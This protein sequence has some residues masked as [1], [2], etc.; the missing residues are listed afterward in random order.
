MFIDHI[1]TV[2]LHKLNTYIQAKNVLGISKAE[3]R[4]NACLKLINDAGKLS[5]ETLPEW[6][7]DAGI[8]A[9]KFLKEP[10]TAFSSHECPDLL[11][12]LISYIKIKERETPNDP[13]CIRFKLARQN[14]I[15]KLIATSGLETEDRAKKLAYLDDYG[16]DSKTPLPPQDIKKYFPASEPVPYTGGAMN[17][18]YYTYLDDKELVKDPYRD[19]NNKIPL[20][21][22]PLWLLFHNKEK[23]NKPG[24]I[25]RFF[26]I[27]SGVDI[28]QDTLKSLQN[29]QAI[30]FSQQTTASSSPKDQK[31][32]TE[33]QPLLKYEM[34][35]KAQ[36]ESFAKQIE[37]LR[38]SYDERVRNLESKIETDVAKVKISLSGQSLI[39]KHAEEISKLKAEH[40]VQIEAL[41]A[42]HDKAI[43]QLQE[44][45]KKEIENEV[46][47]KVD[48][49]LK[50]IQNDHKTALDEKDKKMTE[51]EELKQKLISEHKSAL[52]AK[53][54]AL[55]D[56][57]ARL[58]E[59]EK[60]KDNTDTKTSSHSNAA[61]MGK[62]GTLASPATAKPD[63]ANSTSSS[64]KTKKLAN[65]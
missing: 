18:F 13:E 43:R 34:D 1:R 30:I 28:I 64:T 15:Q 31:S 14:L 12:E 3:E 57:I 62:M 27:T 61:T 60:E 44:T 52:D 53:E 38:K 17:Y 5:P 48:A 54:A 41:K 2:V 8:Y 19:M 55:T 21:L 29:A 51:L 45:H 56:A 65:A 25:A 22:Q 11:F 20:Q 39:P 26:E 63:G 46:K 6:I 35:L 32:S 40:G 7:V 50:K 47:A 16:Q 59:K 4:K 10:W 36:Q 58:K 49:A 37:E 33:A 23:Y 42:E 9:D 24:Q